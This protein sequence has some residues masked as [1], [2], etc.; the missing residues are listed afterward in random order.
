M[1]KIISGL[2]LIAVAVGVYWFFI[3]SEKEKTEKQA[4][5]EVKGANTAFDKSM[6]NLMILYYVF[7]DAFVKS[8]S[9][10]V[11]KI[12]PELIAA[13]Y[14]VDIKGLKADTAIIATAQGLKESILAEAATIPKTIGLEEKRHS[15][16]V[17]SDAL[18][19]MVR[20]VKYNR[21]TIYQLHCPMA[22]DN[23]GANWLSKDSVITNPYF[24]SKMIDC[25]GVQDTYPN[26]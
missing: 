8:D 12:T 4:A 7:K 3:R 10:L 11:D 1:R 19:D 25:G 15:L 17:I 9:N 5:L 24:G 18:Y 26:K 13:M 23:A 21:D 20:A 6:D 2:V 16:E 14:A 22:F